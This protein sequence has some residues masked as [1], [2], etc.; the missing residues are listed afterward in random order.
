MVNQ[1]K[2]ADES[3]TE[4]SA[5]HFII[6]VRVQQI[7]M[8]VYVSSDSQQDCTET[9]THHHQQKLKLHQLKIQGGKHFSVK[10]TIAL[11]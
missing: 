5:M 3:I 11:S 6:S 9:N 4:R 7:E 2:S 1:E 10:H 8:V